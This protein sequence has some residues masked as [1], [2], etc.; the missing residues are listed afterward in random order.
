MQLCNTIIQ[1]VS[2][3]QLYMVD[4]VTE[5]LLVLFSWTCCH[6]SIYMAS[7]LAIYI[8]CCHVGLVVI[9]PV[10]AVCFSF[11]NTHQSYCQWHYIFNRYITCIVL[12]SK[13]ISFCTIS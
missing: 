9:S 11:K 3:R 12:Y 10:F 7:K 1:S 2:Y 13:D 6:Q 8:L 5:L 4:F